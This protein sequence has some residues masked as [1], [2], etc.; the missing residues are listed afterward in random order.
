MDGKAFEGGKAENHELTIGSKTF[1]PG[2]EDQIIGM[3]ID[4]EKDIN[5]K[6]PEEYFSEELKGK[7]DRYD[8]NDIIG[9]TGIE[10]IF[11]DYIPKRRSLFV[12]CIFRTG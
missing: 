10:Y 7:E 8:A 4:E 11:E 2:F 5:V 9:E 6:F 12:C 3:K 1:I